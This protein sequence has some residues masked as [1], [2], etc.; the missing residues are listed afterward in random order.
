[1]S[2]FKSVIEQWLSDPSSEAK[3]NN[4]DTT[5]QLDHSNNNNDNTSSDN[6]TTTDSIKN[7]LTIP[8]GSVFSK[9]KQAREGLMSKNGVNAGKSSTGVK[10]NSLAS[11]QFKSTRLGRGTQDLD[12]IRE[13]ES[14]E[15]REITQN[16]KQQQQRSNEQQQQTNNEQP[17]F[18][19]DRMFI[20]WMASVNSS[21]IISSYKTHRV[22][23]LGTVKD[24]NTGENKSCMWLTNFNRPMGVHTSRDRIWISSSGNLWGYENAGSEIDNVHFGRYDASY[25]P[26]F[27]YF[28]NDVDT[29]DIC[30][31]RDGNPYYCSALFSCICMPSETHSFKVFWKPPWITKIAPEDRCHL[32]G[33]CSRDGV[34]RYVT[35][36][37]Q[38]DVRGAWRENRVEKGIVYDIVENRV[39]CRGL[40]MPHSPRWFNDKLY[41]LDAGSG[42]F[43]YVDFETERLVRKIWIPGYLRGLD[44][45][46]EKY[47]VI[48]SS[49]DRHENCFQGLPLGTKMEEQGVTAKCGIHVIDLEN[50]T[51]PHSVRFFSPMD[52]LYDVCVINGVSRPKI[53]QF[54]DE[55]NMRNY[56]IDHGDFPDQNEF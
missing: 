53:V 21:L 50:Y 13:L 52:E 28:S 19:M 44:F 14:S 3:T 16:Q 23:S 46:N 1:M 41:V 9:S 51:I 20:N 8:T 24:P 48:G 54:M 43:G 11:Y 32:N 40:S 12:K 38:T 5:T 6:N 56:K 15:K 26:R 34:P 4:E 36:V 47:A 49:E 42:W 45:V 55:S 2:S 22:I 30:V 31:D 17:R 39:V 29:H 7:S 27:A 35:S 18:E 33:V 25:I 37:C 10:L